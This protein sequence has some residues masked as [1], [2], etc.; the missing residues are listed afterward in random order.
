MLGGP[1]Q[2]DKHRV[3]LAQASLGSCSMTIETVRFMVSMVQ[4]C[5]EYMI[6]I[7]MHWNYSKTPICCFHVLDG[8]TLCSLTPGMV[9]LTIWIDLLGRHILYH[10]SR[11]NTPRSSAWIYAESRRSQLGERC[12]STKWFLASSDSI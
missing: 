12:S 1:H 9:F 4:V 10:I 3:S 5:H 2:K 7:S 11:P 6:P 8:H